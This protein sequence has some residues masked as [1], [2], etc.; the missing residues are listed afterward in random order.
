MSLIY[1]APRQSVANSRSWTLGV[2]WAALA[3]GFWLLLRGV[4]PQIELSV[5][6]QSAQPDVVQVFYDRSHQG[7]SESESVSK[8]LHVGVN[9]IEFTLPPGP[10]FQLR[11]DPINSARSASISRIALRQGHDS[12]W[13]G[14]SIDSWLPGPATAIDRHDGALALVAGATADPQLLFI[15]VEPL[16]AS[17]SNASWFERILL[18]ALYALV[19]LLLLRLWLARSEQITRFF[20]PMG[21]AAA[22]GLILALAMTSTTSRS[23]HP[24]EFSHLGVYQYYAAHWL[25]PAVD[26]P[27]TAAS[28]S[29]WGYSYLF[30]LDIVYEFVARLTAPL[31][32]AIHDEL[33]CARL[34]QC[35]L[36]AI[37]CGVAASRRRWAS[38]LSVTL[39]SP[40]IWYIYS[41]LNA[42][43]FALFLAL[44]A[45]VLIADDE[46]GVHR[47]L[48]TGEKSSPALWCTAACLGLLLVSK[49]N[50]L[51]VVPAFLLWLAIVHLELSTRVVAAILGGLLVLGI[52]VFAGDIPNMMPWR[53]PLMLFGVL[54]VVGTTL[55]S[56]WRDYKD[57]QKRSVLRRLAAFVLICAAIAAPRVV[58][59]VHVNGWPQEK[60]ARIHATVEAR[61]GHDF[62]PSVTAQGKGEP[63]I[64]L[65]ARGVRLQNVIFAPY[66]W[67]YS[68]LISA[69]GVYGYMNIVAQPW[70][71][72]CISFAAALILALVVLAMRRADPSRWVALAT[73]V[74][75]GTMLVLTS[76]LLWSWVNAMQ[77]Q[78]RYLFPIVPMMAL[79][80]GYSAPYLPKRIFALLIGAAFCMSAG[81]FALL[82]LPA[83]AA[84]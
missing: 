48:R 35:A 82:A 45:A 52:A 29:I 17:Q 26:D 10:I 1:R 55:S 4:G 80:F 27:V 66:G 69:F 28:S 50:Y 31:M 34:F 76:S 6:V 72:A 42:D 30:E 32:A 75:G 20:I 24:D 47:F 41:Y 84:P 62:K 70:F 57:S 25:P 12:P 18:A 49:R 43:A 65:A 9:H 56:C 60:A 51:P 79:L 63:S 16:I 61:A 33:R 59:D 44:L 21:M 40:Q 11:L 67:A 22:G 46:S 71:Y 19:G 38:T 36:W 58:W 5:D 7:F 14:L 53:I 13:Q 8:P 68:S 77:A 2:I 37:L 81:S 74:G 15:P 73:C 64:G 54:L 39:L 23:V 3:L 78:G 83:F